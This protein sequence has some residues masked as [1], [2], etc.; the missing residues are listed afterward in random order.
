[1][2]FDFTSAGET[3]GLRQLFPQ[4]ATFGGAWH[5]RAFEGYTYQKPSK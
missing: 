1:M 2:K 3:G 4:V 5:W